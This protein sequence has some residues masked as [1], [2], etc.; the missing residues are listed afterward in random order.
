LL[1]SLYSIDHRNFRFVA[2]GVT[3]LIIF[4][5]GGGGAKSIMGIR[6]SDSSIPRAIQRTVFILCCLYTT[7]IIVLKILNFLFAL[8][9][10]EAPPPH[11]TLFLGRKNMGRHSLLLNPKSYNYARS[12]CCKFIKRPKHSAPNLR[13]SAIKSVVQK[14][15]A[16]KIIVQDKHDVNTNSSSKSKS[17]EK[18]CIK[19]I[20][21][22]REDKFIL[23]LRHSCSRYWY[24]TNRLTDL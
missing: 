4:A 15:S 18:V 19:H 12:H 6:N 3:L 5:V 16:I 2:I 14:G 9:N 11:K 23:V 17:L 20:P 10:L 21:K 13:T 8:F 24:K 7:Q 1:F 22:N